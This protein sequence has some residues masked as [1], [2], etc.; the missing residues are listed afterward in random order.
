MTGASVARTVLF[1]LLLVQT[2]LATAAPATPSIGAQCS[3]GAGA[4]AAAAPTP[5]T[6]ISGTPAPRGPVVLQA[7]ADIPLPGSASRFDYQSLGATDG[8]LAI[9][10]MGA[11]QVVIFDTVASKVVGAIEDIKAPTGIIT[12]PDLD[13]IFVSASGSH[14]VAVVNA[15]SLAVIAH[16]G[17]IGFPDGLDYAPVVQHVFVS[18]ESGGGEVVIDA[19]T[20]KV[21]TTIDIGGAAGNTH[22]DPVS[23]CILVAVHDQHQLAV[24]DP[25]T[26]RVV[27]HFNLGTSCQ[28][29]HGFVI[30]ARLRQAFVA[31]Q[32]EARLVLVDLQTR[33][34]SAPYP[35]GKSPD[36]LAFD[37]DRRQL[38]VASES[39]DVSVFVEDDHTLTA[40]GAYQAPHAHSIA[41]DPRTHQIYLPLE[42]VDGKPVLRILSPIST[43]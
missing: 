15:S 4:T 33:E 12:V 1:A 25:A 8:R 9:S 31:C 14:D 17:Q 28:S 16:I 23:G 2:P 41:V 6:P 27:D 42:D 30:A 34:V 32:D 36:V 24:I 19:R 38:Y 35:V 5:A 7:E 20:N 43:P 13:R 39:G 40:V 37:A 22:Y 29:P 21:V 11:D 10:H 18:D 3:A 26:N